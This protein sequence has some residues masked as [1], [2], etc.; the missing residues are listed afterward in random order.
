VSAQK[1]P[2]TATT[3]KAH[4]LGL[5]S[6]RRPL[7]HPLPD[8]YVKKCRNK[9]MREGVEGSTANKKSAFAPILETDASGGGCINAFNAASKKGNEETLAPVT[10]GYVRNHNNKLVREG[11][12]AKFSWGSAA[13]ATARGPLKSGRGGGQVVKRQRL[14]SRARETAAS[15]P[16]KGLAA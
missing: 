13:G 3:L 8:G 2:V 12:V 15:K 1:R 16:N 5:A 4:T 9:L 10:A 14:P 7:V 6:T 11:V